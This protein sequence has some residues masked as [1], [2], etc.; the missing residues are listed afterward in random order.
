M[1]GGLAYLV[2]GMIGD[3]A[4]LMVGVVGVLVIQLVWMVKGLLCLMSLRY[5]Q[6]SGLDGWRSG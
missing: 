5:G 2:V 3:L 6:I 1:V 4:R